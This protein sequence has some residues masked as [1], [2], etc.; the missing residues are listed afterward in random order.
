MA[1]PNVTLERSWTIPFAY[2]AVDASLQVCA[3]PT[4]QGDLVVRDLEDGSVRARF[5]GPGP[6]TDAIRISPA[7]HYL[8]VPCT[9]QNSGLSL[10][11]WL[12]AGVRAIQHFQTM[13][14]ES[15]KLNWPGSELPSPRGLAVY[16]VDEARL[17]WR[18][19]FGLIANQLEFSSDGKLIA[20]A[21]V[22]GRIHVFET[23]SGKLINRLYP[24]N[25][26]QFAWRPYS[27]QLTIAD[28]TPF[29]RLIN[30]FSQRVEATYRLPDVVDDI[31]WQQS[32][33]SFAAISARTIYLWDAEANQ[34]KRIFREHPSEPIVK[35]SFGSR[36]HLCASSDHDGNTLVWAPHSGRLLT[37]IKGYYP[38]VSETDSKLATTRAAHGRLEINVW[39]V[40]ESAELSNFQIGAEDSA[41]LQSIAYSPDGQTIAA[42]GDDGLYVWKPKCPE[43]GRFVP[44]LGAFGV[45]AGADSGQWLVNSEHGLLSVRLSRSSSLPAVIEDLAPIRPSRF[46]NVSASSDG[47]RI[48]ASCGRGQVLLL[49]LETGRARHFEIGNDESPIAVGPDGTW[50]V[51]LVGTRNKLELLAWDFQTG[52][53]LGK[54]GNCKKGYNRFAISNDGRRIVVGNSIV[55]RCFERN[56]DGAWRGSWTVPRQEAGIW[57]AASFSHDGQTVAIVDSKDM[58]RI[59]EASTGTDLC[60]LQAPSPRFTITDLGFSPDDSLLTLVGEDRQIQCWDI[61]LIRHELAEMQLDW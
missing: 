26:N 25:Y 40:T 9:T 38:F 15:G 36:D 4:S 18:N 43:Q 2:P 14:R 55:Y 29:V 41:Y 50:F 23:A 17:L 53:C 30:V 49:E 20:G 59:I 33:D 47:T 57:G 7:A 5:A 16:S 39:D 32:G 22:D 37:T 45:A 34:L 54:I 8:A 28:Q 24:G 51:S 1:F 6:T 27:A 19:E 3:Y 13:D 35:I 11:H 61:R 44:L 56:A 42:C 10:E 12:R 58:V 60:R 31:M 21:S 46:Y 52:Q 48:G